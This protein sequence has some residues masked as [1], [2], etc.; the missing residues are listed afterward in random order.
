MDNIRKYQAIESKMDAMKREVE[1]L[2]AQK[3]EARESL[4]ELNESDD[5]L[6]EI[7]LQ[8]SN[9]LSQAQKQI[10]AL[11]RSKREAQSNID[12]W[13][14]L[15]TSKAT[16]RGQYQAE[17]QVYFSMIQF[18]LSPCYS[19]TFVNSRKRTT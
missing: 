16:T 14:S 13:Q 12:A 6:N 3:D 2:E 9:E 15:C 4:K 8:R 5:Q 11:D 1:M 17:H 18:A 7:L 10:L 19:N